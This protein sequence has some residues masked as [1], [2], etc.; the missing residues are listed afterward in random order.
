MYHIFFIHSTVNGHLKLLPCLGYCK[1]CCYEH[2]GA[3]IFLD[4]SF[5]WIYDQEW[6]CWV[7]WQLFLVFW[8]N[9]LLFSIVAAPIYIATNHC[10]K[11]PFLEMVSFESISR[12]Y[13]TEGRIRG[14]VGKQGHFKTFISLRHSVLKVSPTSYQTHCNALTSKITRNFYFPCKIWE[15]FYNT[16]SAK[17]YLIFFVISTCI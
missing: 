5:I 11:V 12:A 8:G 15:D 3:W 4:Y 6:D 10:R 7:I 16:K 14:L 17:N 2:R 1:Q 9:S 13:F